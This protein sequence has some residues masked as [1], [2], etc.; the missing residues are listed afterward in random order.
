MHILSHLLAKITFS[1]NNR[2]KTGKSCN[3]RSYIINI[4]GDV[5]FCLFMIFIR[6]IRNIG[7]ELRYSFHIGKK[8]GAY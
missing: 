2:V 6:V 3:K 7:C 4:K 5:V 8:G 1:V